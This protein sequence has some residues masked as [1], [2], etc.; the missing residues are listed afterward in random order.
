MF[1][2]IL[3]FHEALRSGEWIQLQ[4]NEFDHSNFDRI[5]HAF[6]SFRKLGDHVVN[7]FKRMADVYPDTEQLYAALTWNGFY[8][9]KEK[10]HR[11]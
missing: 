6:K 1:K 10:G 9:V 2:Q 4:P 7:V 3:I 11:L 8:V 5:S